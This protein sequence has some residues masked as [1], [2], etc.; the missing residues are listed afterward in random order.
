MTKNLAHSKFCQCQPFIKRYISSVVYNYE[1]VKNG[2][3]YFGCNG[4]YNIQK[5]TTVTCSSFGR[6]CPELQT[7]QDKRKNQ[8]KNE[9][10]NCLGEK[11]DIFPKPHCSDETS[12][13]KA[14]DKE[15]SFWNF[16]DGE[17]GC[18]LGDGTYVYVS[19]TCPSGY[20]GFNFDFNISEKF[21]R[22][23]K[24]EETKSFVGPL[25]VER[26]FLRIDDK[27][28][29]IRQKVTK[30]NTTEDAL[31]DYSTKNCIIKKE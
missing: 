3:V 10:P 19:E 15:P 26:D 28:V 24:H 14:C 13:P 29:L 6:E 11:K 22:K 9:G 1:K 4:D 30:E 5:K 25:H 23:W 12:K 27:C 7:Y 31:A 2:S 17:E 16:N 21:L 20:Q 18:S 8:I